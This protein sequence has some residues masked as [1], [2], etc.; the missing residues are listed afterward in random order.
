M[1]HAL[2]GKTDRQRERAQSSSPAPSSLASPPAARHERLSHLHARYGNQAVLRMV[3][4]RRAVPAAAPSG[5]EGAPAQSA[6][7]TPALVVNTPGDAWEQEADRVAGQVMRM[8]APGVPIAPVRVQR[9]DASAGGGGIAPP[10]VH[11][12]LRSPGQ[13]L[14]AATR[15]F[16]E[17]RFGRD[18]SA[19]R[20]HTDAHAAESARSIDASAYTVGRDVVFGAGQYATSTSK[21]KRLLAH[22]LTHVMQ[23]SAAARGTGTEESMPVHTS[24]HFP[25]H[26]SIGIEAK[27]ATS[28]LQ[29]Q[30]EATKLPASSIGDCN[31][32]FLEGSTAFSGSTDSN[33]CLLEIL[34]Y[35]QSGAARTVALY[36]YRTKADGGRK[37]LSLKRAETVKQWL[38]QQ[39]VSPAQ[40]TIQDMGTDNVDYLNPQDGR[41]VGAALG[42]HAEMSPQT[43]KRPANIEFAPRMIDFLPKEGDIPKKIPPIKGEQ[44]K[45]AE[46]PSKDIVP[47]TTTAVDVSEPFA[48]PTYTAPSDQYS[49]IGT[50]IKQR[51]DPTSRREATP[52]DYVDYHKEAIWAPFLQSGGFG[53]FKF[54][55]PQSWNE[56]GTEIPSNPKKP[57][58]NP[59]L[60]NDYSTFYVNDGITPDNF[61]NLMLGRFITGIGP[62]NFVFPRDGKVS[63][64]MRGSPIVE[65]AVRDWYWENYEAILSG[66]PLHATVGGDFGL[67]EQVDLFMEKLGFLNVP[68]FVGSA[69]VTVT[70]Q[71][72]TVPNLDNVFSPGGSE[73]LLITIKNVTSATSGDIKKHLPGFGT[74]PSF[75]KDTLDPGRQQFT[76]ISQTFEFTIDLDR[77]RVRQLRDRKRW[78]E[79]TK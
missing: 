16:M 45:K 26:Q 11:E 69:T 13:P 57:A 17:A 56:L 3:D 79:E 75:A 64:E 29:R 44:T 43:L 60:T 7:T 52:S 24:V 14:D 21:G 55:N 15:A 48:L 78:A 73:K 2:I 66:S 6:A 19:V 1:L 31:I 27:V 10:I 33:N 4:A 72:E 38:E 51:Y 32:L 37:D 58:K 8:A 5:R 36:G 40:I 28:R 34:T 54:F 61:V 74:A 50:T 53:T 42:G 22:E 12:V 20:V 67:S 47:P 62:E 25:S 9:H 68:Q 70:P 30:A 39:G 18:F 23:Q 65:N 49:G 77:S 59:H 46:A 63:N 41:R 76:N 35:L 71:F